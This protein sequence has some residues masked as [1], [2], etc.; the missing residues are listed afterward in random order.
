MQ[1]AKNQFLRGR[2][3]LSPASWCRAGGLRTQDTRRGPTARPQTGRPVIWPRDSRRS[4][5]GRAPSRADERR[6]G[7]APCPGHRR[8]CVEGP[9]EGDDL[10]G[11]RS[12]R[13][14]RERGRP[15]IARGD[16][17]DPE[18]PRGQWPTSERAWRTSARVRPSLSKTSIRV[19]YEVRLTSAA[20]RHLNQLGEGDR[21]AVL[22]NDLR[23]ARAEPA[24][25]RK[26]APATA[27]RAPRSAARSLPHRLSRGR[28]RRNG[29]GPPD[30]PPTRRVPTLIG[31]DVYRRPRYPRRS[32][33]AF[34]STGNSVYRTIAPTAIGRP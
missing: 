1:L 14:P 4:S 27:R 3:S 25:P 33:I 8:L 29:D 6:R 11:G 7:G 19:T 28:G 30:R 24:S 18:R 12:S 10:G 9:V 16:A 26:T 22:E 20:R 13:R 32:W 2:N 21:A 34:V 17:G 5:Y 31:T 15:R 23:P